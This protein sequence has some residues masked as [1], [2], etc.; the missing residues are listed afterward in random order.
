MRA[1]ASWPCGVWQLSHSH[2]ERCSSPCAGN[3]V[4]GLSHSCD[5]VRCRHK[6]EAIRKPLKTEL[7]RCHFD[8]SYPS[9]SERYKCRNDMALTIRGTVDENP[10]ALTKTCEESP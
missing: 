9:F 5:A 6:L 4:I 7:R 3:C 2:R 10:R 1:G 8:S